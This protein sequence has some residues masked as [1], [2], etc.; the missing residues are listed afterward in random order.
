L[1]A[2]AADVHEINACGTSPLVTRTHTH[3]H[4]HTSFLV[5]PIFLPSRR[6]S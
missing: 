5:L 4:R 6:R 1:D 3:T 2:S